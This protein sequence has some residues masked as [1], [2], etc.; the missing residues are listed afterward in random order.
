MQNGHNRERGDLH[1]FTKW[2]TGTVAICRNCK[3]E[4]VIWTIFQ[5][6]HQR[7]LVQ[8]AKWQSKYVAIWIIVTRKT[9]ICIVCI[10]HLKLNY[11]I[12]K[13]TLISEIV[14]RFLRFLN[15]EICP[16]GV[17]MP[18]LVQLMH[19]FLLF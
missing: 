6:G 7:K 1:S 17:K 10:R 12:T 2:T 4:V 15:F 11:K 9:V 18:K 13:R 16:Y 8:F 19:D 5:N 14:L 3:I